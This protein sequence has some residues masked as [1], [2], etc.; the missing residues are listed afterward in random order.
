M[1]VVM[2]RTAYH[3]GPASIVVVQI[4]GKRVVLQIGRTF[5]IVRAA[6]IVLT[7]MPEKGTNSVMVA[8]LALFRGN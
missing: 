2:V 5:S 7:F 8:K 4:I 6:I 1:K 3:M